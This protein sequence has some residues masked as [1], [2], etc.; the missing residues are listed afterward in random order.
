MTHPISVVFGKEFKDGRRDKRAVM[1]A[2]LFPFFAPIIVY[3]MMTAIIE[4]RTDTETLVI[5][6]IG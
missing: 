1:S 4:L 5:P 3:F 2:F 6:V